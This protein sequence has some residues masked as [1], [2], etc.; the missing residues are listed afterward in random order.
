MSFEGQFDPDD[1]NENSSW[2][3]SRNVIGDPPPKGSHLESEKSILFHY[4]YYRKIK[5][6]GNHFAVCLKYEEISEKNKNV[7]GYIA[8]NPK[9]SNKGGSTTGLHIVFGNAR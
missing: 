4:N 5:E 2:S 6:D 7:K 1:V 8:K 3:D 9:F